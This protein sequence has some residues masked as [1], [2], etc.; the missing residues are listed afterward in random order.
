[1]KE[2]NG[3]TLIA[4]IITIIIMLILVAVTI[5]MAVNGGLFGYAGNAAKDTELAKNAELGLSNGGVTIDEI[6]DAYK[7]S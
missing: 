3:I 2:K 1:M 7:A 6:T 5:M 4:L